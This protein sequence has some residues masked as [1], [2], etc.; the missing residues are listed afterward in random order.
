MTASGVVRLRLRV[1][2]PT[3]SSVNARFA[4]EWRRT[5]HRSAPGRHGWN[6]LPPVPR[7][8]SGARAHCSRRP[9][10][11]R[12]PPPQAIQVDPVP[13]PRRAPGL[14]QGDGNPWSVISRLCGVALLQDAEWTSRSG[15]TTTATPEQPPVTRRASAIAPVV[16]YS[17]RSIST[18]SRP[19]SRI[20]SASAQTRRRVSISAA[21]GLLRKTDGVA[22]SARS[23]AGP[24]RHILPVFVQQASDLVGQVARV[25]EVRSLE[26]CVAK[27]GTDQFRFVEVGAPQVGTFQDRVRQPSLIEHGAPSRV[28]SSVMPR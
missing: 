2:V 13:W 11:R 9:R 17:L 28:P 27:G 23:V 18:T 6:G 7:R 12:R 16:A 21:P 22:D 25:S 19:C 10:E 26:S 1:A 4:L 20:L 24:P 3:K 8:R 5:N 15:T 14:V